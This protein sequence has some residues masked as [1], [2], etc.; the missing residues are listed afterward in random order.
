MGMEP[1][2]E[3]MTLNDYLEYKAEKERR[4]WKSVAPVWNRV[5]V[6]HDPDEEDKEISGENLRSME[7]EEVPNRFNEEIVR[8][9][10]HES[11]EVLVDDIE[12]GEDHDVD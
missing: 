9:T 5:L 1:D 8:D 4:F 6:Y 3:N 12:M 2:N 7:H 11:E 10:D